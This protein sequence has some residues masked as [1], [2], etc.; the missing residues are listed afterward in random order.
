M[1]PRSIILTS[2]TLSPLASF[3]AELQVKF[4][5]KLES[6]H[7]IKNDQVH[8]SIMKT[9]TNGSEFNFSY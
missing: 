7:V 8:I 9:S 4:N 1:E 6:P 3:E 5:Q 2:G